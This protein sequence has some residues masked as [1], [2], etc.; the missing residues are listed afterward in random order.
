MAP[1]T[2]EPITGIGINAAPI[3]APAYYPATSAAVEATVFP[4][5]ITFYS[6]LRLSSH[7]TVPI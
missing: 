1:P 2:S 3:K 7:N 4:T 5:S 6:P